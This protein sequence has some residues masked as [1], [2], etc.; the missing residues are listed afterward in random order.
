VKNLHPTRVRADFN[1]LFGQLLCLSHEE[2][3]LGANGERIVVYEGLR[4]TAFDDDVD[5]HGNPDKLLAT[6]V[7]EKSPNWLACSGS[8]WVLRLDENGWFNE[9]DL[10]NETQ[11]ESE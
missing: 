3:C 8:R 6:G 9:S 5:E 10:L 4:V 2:T 11:R 7:V 1:G